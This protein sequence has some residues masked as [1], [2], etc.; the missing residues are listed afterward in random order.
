MSPKEAA[1]LLAAFASAYSKPLDESA[2]ELWYQ[3][4]LHKVDYAVAMKVADRIVSHDEW[5][6]T[7]ARF[8]E[9]RRV[10]ERDQAEPFRAL[11]SPEPAEGERSRVK[12]LI[13]DM[14]KRLR[15]GPDAA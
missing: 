7:P 11:P 15:D 14:R 12:Q 4:T 10:V 6:P 5:F 2:V 1:Q 13:A 9:V 8:N 3:S